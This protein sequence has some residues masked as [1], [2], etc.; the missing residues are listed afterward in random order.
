MNDGPR[1]SIGTS[2]SSSSGDVSGLYVMLRT[3]VAEKYKQSYATA[4]ETMSRE[5]V[6]GATFLVLIPSTKFRLVLKQ[7]KTY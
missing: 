5:S 2:C 1:T 4:F 3:G 6:S 7:A